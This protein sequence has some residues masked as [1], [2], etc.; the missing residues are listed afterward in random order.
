[1]TTVKTMLPHVQ[2]AGGAQDPSKSHGGPEREEASHLQATLWEN[3]AFVAFQSLTTH[4]WLA[5]HEAGRPAPVGGFYKVS[6]P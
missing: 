5:H 3:M 6:V 4:S 2:A 1:M